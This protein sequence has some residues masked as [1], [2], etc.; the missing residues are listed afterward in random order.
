MQT[1][2][3]CSM[4]F[5]IEISEIDLFTSSHFQSTYFDPFKHGLEEKFQ[6]SVILL[7]LKGI[8]SIV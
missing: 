1:Y 4:H 5:I 6:F 7:L 8:I 2:L 3:L